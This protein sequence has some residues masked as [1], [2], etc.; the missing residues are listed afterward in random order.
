MIDSGN[1]RHLCN[2]A[3]RR[4]LQAI[5]AF[6]A[7]SRNGGSFAATDTLRIS[8]PGP[9]LMPFFP[10]ELIPKLGVD[11]QL[12]TK[13]AIRYQPSGVLALEDVLAGNAAFAGTG[14]PVLPK[15]LEQ[16]HRLVAI[17]RLTRGAPPYAIVV[18]SDLA[19]HIRDIRD[20][21]GHTLGVPIGSPTT[22]TYLQMVAEQWMAAHGVRPGQVRWAPVVQNYEGVAGAMAG[23]I[24]DAVFVEEPYSA[25]LVRAGLGRVLAS[26][27]DPRQA[28]GI[29]GRDHLRAVLVTT[30]AYIAA[31]PD[32][33][34]LMVRMLRRALQ[35][36]AAATPQAIVDR[37]D[38]A[39]VEQR[40]D[41]VDALTRL[42]RSYSG[43]GRFE[44]REF[45]ATREFLRA[46]GI[47]LPPGIDVKDLV[48]DRW[49]NR[50]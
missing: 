29:A 41:L 31:H 44:E 16:G 42:P 15:F 10:V 23:Q 36:S 1:D 27:N 48:D 45:A 14:F 21:R 9:L 46:V 49:V 38:I 4:A 8:I 30:P 47:A 24:V 39:D 19:D 28:G 5:V 34:E 43:D 20:L 3:R 7:L 33:V 37:L 12:D 17:A 13:V 26:L 22:K 6:V 25:S 50:D 18:R 2:R 32:R 11:R 35:W 40:V